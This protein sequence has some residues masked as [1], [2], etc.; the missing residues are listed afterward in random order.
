MKGVGG[1]VKIFMFHGLS[2]SVDS[3]VVL[4]AWR[5]DMLLDSSMMTTYMGNNYFLHNQNIAPIVGWEE[6]SKMINK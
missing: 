4:V 3:E 2:L 5:W 1:A 6:S